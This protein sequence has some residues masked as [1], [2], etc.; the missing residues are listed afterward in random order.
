MGMILT[1]A[2]GILA[3]ASKYTAKRFVANAD[4]LQFIQQQ[5]L[6]EI[7][8]LLGKTDL[9]YQ[10]FQQHYPLTRYAA[11]RE[12]IEQSRLSGRNALGKEVIQRFQPTS[13]SSEQLKYIPYTAGF[14]KELDQ[15]IALWIYDLYQ[16]YP[17]LKQGTHYWSVS[18]LPESL[19]QH[20]ERENLN[21][22]HALLNFSKRLLSGLTQSVPTDIAYAKTAEAAMFATAVYLVADPKLALIS[23][24]SP[25][26]AL[27]LLDLISQKQHEI[28]GVLRS[29]QWPNQN[30][31]KLKAPH[32]PQRAKQF[33][34]L[35][36][37]TSQ[38][39]QQLW[40]KLCLLSSWDT[41]SASSWAI[42]LQQ[43]LP[44]VSFQAKGLWATEAVVTIPYQQYFPLMYHAHFYEFL[45]TDG[46][47]LPAWQLQQ[48]QIVSPVVTTAAGLLRY[49]IDDELQ[50]TGFIKDVPCFK[51]LGR[52]LT[53][54]M[55]GE[56]I[57]HVTAQQ[58]LQ[59]LQ[60]EG[61]RTLSLL[62][63][64]G[65]EQYKPYYAL[66]S[67]GDAEQ[68]PSAAELD[69]LLKRNFH[70]ELARDLGQLAAP[71]VLHVADGWAHY[72][73]L[74][75]HNGM[76]EGNIKPEPLKQFAQYF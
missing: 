45:T 34:R 68:Q 40:P 24:W 69:H 20:G 4:N 61:Y 6:S 51:F 59:Q 9:N 64:A 39:W 14:L 72:K 29:G 47:V 60:T 36:L 58:L 30:F 28:V 3:F 42:Q 18:W 35:D 56:K 25:T 73:R 41:A 5:K 50:V 13:G 71:M 53:V 65:G 26:F 62:G 23:V 8:K 48:D 27:Q 12:V 63:I 1:A 22:D 43:R 31:A 10:Q 32:R 66:L 46:Q 38:A 55:V 16:Q 11:W 15:A 19:R 37:K 75:M 74:A 44:H 52:K 49:I 17:A 57:D 21:N 33:A 76:V 54:D 67:E 2:H 7:L 70:Y